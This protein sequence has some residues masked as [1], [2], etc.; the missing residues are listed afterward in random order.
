VP[1]HLNTLNIQH[2]LARVLVG[3][4]RWDERSNARRGRRSVIRREVTPGQEGMGRTLLVLGRA[5]IEKGSL[6]EAE[7]PVARGAR[8]FPA[9]ATP[10]KQNSRRRRRI[11]SAPFNCVN[12]N[13]A[14]AETALR[15]SGETLLK[16]R[17]ITEPERQEVI[18][19]ISWKLY[20]AL[21]KRP[22]PDGWVQA[23]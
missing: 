22:T 9:E 8:P 5:L 2:L 20:Q 16:A 7:T 11:G 18:G 4:K 15:N 17:P 13:Y 1:I 6:E 12:G 14:E 21:G 19:H 3:A 10:R 23:A